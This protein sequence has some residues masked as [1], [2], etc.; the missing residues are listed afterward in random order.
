[1]CKIN[2][3]IEMRNCLYIQFVLM[4]IFISVYLYIYSIKIN[5]LNK[6][7]GMLKSII[8]TGMDIIY[9]DKV[10]ENFNQTWKLVVIV[11]IWNQ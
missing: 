7:V 11:F 6:K 8:I 3:F 2:T 9:Y 10:C 1:M 4:Y 5:T